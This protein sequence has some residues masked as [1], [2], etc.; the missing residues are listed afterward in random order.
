MVTLPVAGQE[1]ILPSDTATVVEEGQPAVSLSGD[2]AT[3]K[4]DSVESGTLPDESATDPLEGDRDNQARTGRTDPHA[5]FQQATSLYQNEQYEEALQL[6]RKVVEQGYESPDLYYNMGNA[7][8][9]SNN[10]GYAIL[11]Y[12]KALKMNPSHEDASHNLEYVSRYK[13]DVFDEVPELFYK[14]WTRTWKNIMSE[15]AWSIWSMVFF[16]L[17]AV[18]VLVYLFSRR[19]AL[20]KAGFFTAVVLAVFFT[21]S[22]ATAIS[23]H[24]GIADPSSGVIISPSVVVRSSPSQSGTELFILHEGTSVEISEEV[25]GWRN[26]SVVDGREG[27]I[28]AG[29][30]EPV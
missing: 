21:L 6:Y 13:V 2:A 26:I 20:K 19:L 15:R 12:E 14:S 22:L 8:Y 23:R 17:M 29:D 3:E 16:V 25:S 24:R 9:R 18:S 10:I 7:A 4:P 27:W 1:I 28:T 5:L 30:F 11:Y